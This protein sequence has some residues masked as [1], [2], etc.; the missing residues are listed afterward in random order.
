MAIRDSQEFGSNL[1]LIAHRILNNKRLCQLLVNATQN[2]FDRDIEDTTSLL[3]KNI[4]VV[5]RVNDKDFT[6]EGKIVLV[7]PE[8][9]KNDE[10]DEFKIVRFDVLVYT[11]LDTWIVNDENL[12]PFLVMSE[13]EKSLKNKRINGI[14]VMRYQDFELT[15]LTDKVSCYK[16]S[17]II[18]AFD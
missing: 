3:N 18:D 7:F 6:T 2:P 16:M 12:R 17:F 14:G 8:G 11:V 5:P 13:I 9:H 10:N 1:F 15:T 4:L